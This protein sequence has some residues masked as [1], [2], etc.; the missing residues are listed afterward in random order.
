[1]KVIAIIKDILKG[2]FSGPDW[3]DL[4]KMEK[5]ILKNTK[6]GCGNTNID[7]LC[8]NAFCDYCKDISDLRKKAIRK[9]EDNGLPKL[10]SWEYPPMPS[11]KPPRRE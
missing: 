6:Q 1:M 9:F 3:S 2:I 10:H 5:A 7:I 4:T 11:V 8:R